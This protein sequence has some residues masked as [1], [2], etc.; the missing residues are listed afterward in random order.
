MQ[1]TFNFI[2]MPL[3]YIT[4]Y[5]SCFV[6]PLD[7]NSGSKVDWAYGALGVR[8]A[9]AL[10]LWDKGRYGFMLSANQIAPTGRE[11]FAAIKAMA[12]ELKLN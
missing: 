6:F 8:Y 12:K 9:I 4:T 2:L 7:E 11:T 5:D 10:E 1:K 3:P